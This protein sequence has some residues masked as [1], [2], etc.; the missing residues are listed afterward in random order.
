MFTIV[1]SHNLNHAKPHILDYKSKRDEPR[2]NRQVFVQLI[3]IY[4]NQPIRC[5]PNSMPNKTL[6]INF[7]F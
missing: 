4:C 5:G 1:G 6:G 7:Y 2:H 3:K